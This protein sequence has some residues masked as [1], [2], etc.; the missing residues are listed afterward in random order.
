MSGIANLCFRRALQQ[1]QLSRSLSTKISRNE[2]CPK[3]SSLE[4]KFTSKATGVPLSQLSESFLDGT[5][6]DYVEQQFLAWRKDP[7]SVHASWSAFFKNIEANLPPG[8]AYMSPPN[9]HQYQSAIPS[10]IVYVPQPSTILSQQASTSTAVDNFYAINLIDSFRS[11]GHRHAKLDPLGISKIPDIPEL[12]YKSHGFNEAD[13]SKEY[14]FSEKGYN[15][16]NGQKLGDILANLSKVYC[17]TIGFEYMHIEV[18]F[19]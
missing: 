2:I 11:R 15:G 14:Y 13:L 12:N 3:L 1:Q 8:L 16:F 10:Q 18:S 5:S 17:S 19:L 6:A 4:R 9:L 7:N